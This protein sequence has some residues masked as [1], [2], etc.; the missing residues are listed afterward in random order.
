[1][2]SLPEFRSLKAKIRVLCKQRRIRLEE[3][4]KTFDTHRVKKIRTEQF[5]RALDVS[6]LHLSTTEMNL[7]LAKYRIAEDPSFVDYGRFCDLMDKVFTVKGLEAK[8]TWQVGVSTDF[9]PLKTFAFETLTPA[10]D[11]TL[12]V[13]KQKLLAA[14]MHKGIVLKD[15]FHDF[16]RSNAGK[17]TRPQ[18]VR[19]ISDIVVLSS[20]EMDVLLKA[21]GDKL[22]VH[23]RALHFD[24]CPGASGAGTKAA[25]PRS[26]ERRHLATPSG[27][28]HSDAVQQLEAELSELAMRDRIRLKNFFTDFDQLR[29]SKCTEAQFRRCVKLC[30]PI[31]SD[32]DLTLLVQKYGTLQSTKVDYIRFC[33]SVDGRGIQ[34]NNYE[35]ILE[36]ITK[37][38]THTSIDK[39]SRVMRGSLTDNDATVHQGM[40][41]RLHNFCSTR[42]MLLKP[43]FQDFDKGRREHITVDQ[44]FRVMAMFKLKLKGESEKK[45]LLR[46][47][48][49]SHGERFV[50]YVTFCYD[51][52]NWGNDNQ[53]SNNRPS[54]RGVVSEII[55]PSKL[56]TDTFEDTAAETHVR[57]IP[58]LIRYI[59]QTIKRDR[60]RLEEYY[61]DFD[62]LR[63]GKITAAQFYAGL[64]AAGFLLSREEMTL[65]GEEY[66][67]K[68]VDSMGKH[69]IAWKTFVDDVESVFTVKGL[70]KNP[71]HDLKT[72]QT[73]EGQF[74]G[75]VIDKDLTPAEEEEMKQIMLT[76]K[77]AIDR[78]RMEIKPTFEDFDRS[79]QGFIS[80]TK[81][82]RVLSMLTLLPAKASDLRLL[83][84]KFREQAAIGTSATLSSI[85]DVNYR[86][87]LLALQILG[88]YTKNGDSEAI[89]NLVLPGSVAFR[90]EQYQNGIMNDHFKRKARDHH[91]GTANLP[92]L[93][94]ELRRQLSV[95]R[96][97]LKEFIV[98]GDKLRSGEIT[99]A[100]FHTALNR[101]GCVLDADDIQ[102]L[103]SHFRSTKNP[104]KIDWRSFLG[105]LDFSHGM[106]SWQQSGGT[107]SI[108]RILEKLRNEVNHRRLHMKPYF[109]DYDHNNVTHVTK[110]QF[111]AVLDMMQVSLKPA[112]VQALTHQFAHRDGRKLTN[113]VNY[114]AFIQAVDSDYS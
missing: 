90:Q 70:E 43:T 93:L 103:S 53:H 6:G 59:K 19:D 27:T 71:H 86:A 58:M 76:M 55:A 48:A 106:N 73:R 21:Y 81:F 111:A 41:Q 75:V 79:K 96:I 54:S 3:F 9:E 107:D 4:M 88:A 2:H 45:A 5:K 82:E 77:R 29:T 39:C 34:D 12:A 78:Q 87:F 47:Y 84:I 69:W 63:H 40:M 11:K 15:V 65:L 83:L 95:K 22:D 32:S 101:S 36:T 91:S 62:K 60:I 109:Q 114:L 10:E 13:V 112:E 44:F 30:F 94:A 85:C 37:N 57:S 110:F 104:D 50:N 18:F 89:K 92:Q 80:A 74:G 7:L 68:E 66:A 72:L 17:V 33:S 98:E 1:M 16:D 56:R 28:H 64:D 26:P 100:K 67:C 42:R 35:E 31:V 46:R 14:V 8:R 97:R 49:S 102:T 24:I 108:N 105:A 61:R 99:V 25:Q 113:D 20:D 38:T 52:E 23:Y 51:L